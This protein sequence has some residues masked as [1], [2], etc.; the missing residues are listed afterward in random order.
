M[1]QQLVIRKNSLLI[2][3]NACPYA[4]KHMSPPLPNTPRN[5]AAAVLGRSKTTKTYNSSHAPHGSRMPAIN[6]TLTRIPTGY[7]APAAASAAGSNRASSVHSWTRCPMSRRSYRPPPMLTPLPLP[8]LLLPPPSGAGAPLRPR[9]VRKSSFAQ[10]AAA[11]AA[12]PLHAFA[13]RAASY[14][15]SWGIMPTAT[16]PLAC[17]TAS[18]GSKDAGDMVDH[19]ACGCNSKSITKGHST[20]HMTICC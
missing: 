4:H 19:G 9:P 6:P 1:H 3:I 10:L 16:G 7:W 8:L 13:L 11:S 12:D 14:G 18:S 15:G 17:E 5:P 2:V 20:K